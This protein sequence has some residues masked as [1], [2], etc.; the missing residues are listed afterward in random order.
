GARGAARRGGAARP[1]S[2][3]RPPAPTLPAPGRPDPPVPAPRAPPPAAP[4]NPAPT[5]TPRPAPQQ[6]RV[7][8][9]SM[10]G[11]TFRLLVVFDRPDNQQVRAICA[12]EKAAGI[13]PAKDLP[14]R[15]VLA[16]DTW[17]ARLG[18]PGPP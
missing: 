11:E 18:S 16:M 8:F 12:N 4:A 3:G 5:A 10:Y 2:P 17:R 9:P 14:Y 15:R 13:S 1:P 7:G 6:D